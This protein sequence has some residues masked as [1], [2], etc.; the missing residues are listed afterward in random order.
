MG[1]NKAVII[2]GNRKSASEKIRFCTKKNTN[3]YK[4]SIDQMLK[5]VFLTNMNHHSFIVVFSYFKPCR[6]FYYIYCYLCWFCY[7]LKLSFLNKVFY[8]ISICKQNRY[9][10]PGWPHVLLCEN[11]SSFYESEIRTFQFYS[12]NSN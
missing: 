5:N 4:K 11:M 9:F 1:T 7:H 12:E 6:H 3:V 10:K 2:V 8:L